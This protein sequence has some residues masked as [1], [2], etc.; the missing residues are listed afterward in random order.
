MDRAIELFFELF[1]GLP[2]QGPGSA[3]CT[4]RALAFVPPLP[5]TAR[6]LD[7]G[8]GTGAQTLDLA[9]V[10]PALLFAVELHEP[11]VRELAAKA[12]RREQP[13]LHRGEA[14]ILA[15]FE[16]QRA[17]DL[18]Q[19]PD[20]VAGPRPERQPRLARGGFHGARV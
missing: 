14:R 5:P 20:E 13:V 11:F 7:I 12:E 6:I 17:V 4:A 8:C 15:L 2:R 19:A 9:R 3:A 18:M 10:T 16:K 1:A